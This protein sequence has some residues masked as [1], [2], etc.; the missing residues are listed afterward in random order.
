MLFVLLMLQLS[1]LFFFDS[2]SGIL[3]LELGRMRN[4][5]L[6]IYTMDPHA[7]PIRI[8]SKRWAA[9]HFRHRFRHDDFYDV[10][11]AF[12]FAYTTLP[13]PSLRMRVGRRLNAN[14]GDL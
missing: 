11:R 1:D 9:R 7:Q 4:G 5:I 2:Y 12:N 14:L 3:S 10:L 6:Y 13:D 8:P